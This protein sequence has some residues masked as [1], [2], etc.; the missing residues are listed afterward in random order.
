MLVNDIVKRVNQ[1]LAGEQ[2]VYTRIKPFLDEVIDDINANLNSTFPTFSDLGESVEGGL[3]TDYNYFPEKYIRSVV[4]KG[5]AYK[6][7]VMDEEGEQIAQMYNYD[8]QRALFHMVRDYIDQV[9]EE[10]QSDSTGSIRLKLDDSVEP[11]SICPYAL[12]W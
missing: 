2:L 4:I 8:Y 1:E 7:Y 11:F 10:Y 9:P 12:R 3:V 6:F 5:A